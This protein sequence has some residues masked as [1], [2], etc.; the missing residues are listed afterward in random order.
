MDLVNI[1]AGYLPRIKSNPTDRSLLVRSELGVPQ[2]SNPGPLL[3]WLYINYLPSSLTC[4]C[5]IQAVNAKL[6]CGV[7]CTGKTY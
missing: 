5:L 4:K 6:Y 3:F 7:I 1:F 2:G